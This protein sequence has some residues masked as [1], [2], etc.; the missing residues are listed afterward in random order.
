MGRKPIGK[1]AMSNAERQAKHRK[2]A[3]TEVQA[4]RNALEHITMVRTAAEAREFA[5]TALA[6]SSSPDVSD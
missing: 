2:K 1:R 6:Y 3:L 5:K 4:W